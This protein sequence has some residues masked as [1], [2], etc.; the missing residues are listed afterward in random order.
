MRIATTGP[1]VTLNPEATQN[2]GLALHE[3]ATNATKHGALSVPKVPSPWTGRSDQASRDRAAFAL[4]GTSIMV[5]R[6]YRRNVGVS[7]MWFC[8]A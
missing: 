3:L 2:I 8:S 4:I 7:V 1:V 5:R 6:W